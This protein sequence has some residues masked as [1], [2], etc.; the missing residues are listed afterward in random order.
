MN[1]WLDRCSFL[2]HIEL[3]GPVA[4]LNYQNLPL[5]QMRD[6]QREGRVLSCSGVSHWVKLAGICSAVGGVLAISVG[7]IYSVK[8]RITLLMLACKNPFTVCE[9]SHLRG[10]DF[11]E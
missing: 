10:P 2:T 8:T 5:T 11:D 6:M 3:K 4:L 9:M 1:R 7:L